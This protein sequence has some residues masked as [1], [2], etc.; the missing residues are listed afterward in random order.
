MAVQW[1]DDSVPVVSRQSPAPAS[2][3]AILQDAAARQSI[4]P[5]L[6]E[7]LIWQE[8]RWHP[9]AVSPA[10]AVGLGQLMP[11]TARHLGVDPRDPRASIHGA[12]RYLREQIDH[13]GGNLELALAAYNA[14]PGR[15][16]GRRCSRH[17][18]NPRLCPCHHQPPDRH[19]IRR[20]PMIR[21]FLLPPFVGHPALAVPARSPPGGPIVSAL[22]W[23]R[24]T[25]LGQ[26]ATTVAVI[27]VAMVGFMMLTGRMNWRFG[28]TVILG[29]FILFG[30]ASIVAGIQ[31]AAGMGG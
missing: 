3:A 2:Y 25:L 16:S 19:H 24:D 28:A 23:V 7:A 11:A 22:T 10:G 1:R 13:F 27:A 18:R 14:G 31:S 8:S 20:R 30:A 5:A 9:D 6:L 12:A 21:K 17:C 29:C 26:V 15:W 4:S